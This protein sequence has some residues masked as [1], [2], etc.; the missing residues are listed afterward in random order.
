MGV[1]I[2]ISSSF[3]QLNIV[4]K[5]LSFCIVKLR[6]GSSVLVISL[7]RLMCVKCEGTYVGGTLEMSIKFGWE[8]L[9]KPA[10]I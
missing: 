2:E 10:N 4:R 8:R 7:G 3:V 1:A 9:T 6:L 5:H